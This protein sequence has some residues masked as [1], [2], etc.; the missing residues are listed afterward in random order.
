MPGQSSSTVS[1]KSVDRESVFEATRCFLAS[2]KETHSELVGAY[3][4][5]SF[6]KG[7]YAPGSDIDILLVLSSSDKVM[8]DRIPDF[9]PGRFPVGVDILPYTVEELEKAE[10][11]NCFIRSILK[12]GEY[13]S[14]QEQV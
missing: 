13:I 10:E 9:L 14:L 2:L 8:R 7:T 3:L 1:I 5:G 6:V 12:Q 11:E 4:F